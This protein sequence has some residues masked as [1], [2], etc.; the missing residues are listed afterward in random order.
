MGSK[1]LLAACATVLVMAGGYVNVQGGT[2]PLPN[3]EKATATHTNVIILIPDG[4]G[5]S[6]ATVSRWV[7]QAQG[8]ELAVDQMKTGLVK[9]YMSNS[10]IPGSATCGTAFACGYKTNVTRLGVWPDTINTP[11]VTAVSDEDKFRPIA[12]VMEAAKLLGKKTG[13]IST[14]DFRHA[15]PAS[16]VAHWYYRNNGDCIAAQMASSNIDLIFGGGS[17]KYITDNACLIDNDPLNIGWD[18][19]ID[20]R[21][22]L[23]NLDE[24]T[25]GRTLGL[26]ADDDLHKELD[27][28]F[29]NVEREPSIAEMTE[30]AID[31]LSQDEDGFVL[32]VEGSQVDWASHGDDPVGV[33]TDFLAFDE[34]V[35]VARDFA[36]E[37][38]ETMVIAVPDHDNGG[39]TVYSDYNTGG[40]SYKDIQP[41]EMVG[42][43]IQAKITAAYLANILFGMYPDNDATTADDSASIADTVGN[44]WPVI[45]SIPMSTE[46]MDGVVD[47]INNGGW[48]EKTLGDIIS[49][50]CYIGWTTGGHT[51]HDVQIWY[52]GY[53]GDINTIDNTE[54]GDLIFDAMGVHKDSVSA[55]L[56][57]DATEAF[58]AAATVTIDTAGCVMGYGSNPYIVAGAKLTVEEGTKKAVFPLNTRICSLYV[59]GTLDTVEE[60]EEGLV[61]YEINTHRAFVPS[62]AVNTFYGSGTSVNPAHLR[63]GSLRSVVTLRSGIL[64]VSGHEH[65]DV[66][67]YGLN[68]TLVQ[69]VRTEGARVDLNDI[70]MSN[71]MYIMSVNGGLTRMKIHRMNGRVMN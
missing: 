13:V 44:Y 55:R 32:M 50:R 17:E 61:V 18:T 10:I 12:N 37:N 31:I 54:V 56:F 39:C 30:R 71:G 19:Y 60:L 63:T 26:F 11:E 28:Q 66:R 6:H 65:V 47:D 21:T 40:D 29:F 43:I 69:H 33:V 1:Q 4:M 3:I 16:F 15:T 51:G 14:S 35:Q 9:T 8:A 27:R 48:L 23:M 67:I 2:V 58:N 24:T 7:A 49:P 53:D 70:A 68:G 36:A 38:G 45:D 5:T 34:A 22:E 25:A 46:E 52:E 57:I 41:H 59:D 62:E 20:E 42:P 64:D